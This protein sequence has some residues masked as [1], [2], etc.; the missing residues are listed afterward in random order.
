MGGGSV[1]ALSPHNLTCLLLRLSQVPME[2][3]SLNSGDCFI[4]DLGLKLIQWNGKSASGFEKAEAAKVARAID[5]ERA[6]KAEV[7][8]LEEGDDRDPQFWDKLGGR[9][10]IKFVIALGFFLSLH[11]P[12][13]PNYF[14]FSPPNVLA[15]VCRGGRP[16]LGGRRAQAADAP[17]GRQRHND[18]QGG[19]HRHQHQARPA[20]VRRRLCL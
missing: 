4:L 18:L 20:Q 10:E 16:R 7:V 5:D 2:R 8:V 14:R 19:G 1:S 11:G 6:G 12:A 9:G 13:S 15:K 3:A 17:V